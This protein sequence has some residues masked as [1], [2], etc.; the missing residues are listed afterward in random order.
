MAEVRG[1]AFARRGEAFHRVEGALARANLLAKWALVDREG[2]NQYPSQLTWFLGEKYRSS[3]L[4]PA[5][6]GGAHS[7]GVRQWTSS[8]F[9][10]EKDRCLGAVMRHKVR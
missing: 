9:R 3:S 5:V 6:A 10:T 1:K 4:T 2:V 7:W 8:V